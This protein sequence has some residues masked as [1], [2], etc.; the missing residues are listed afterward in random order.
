MYRPGVDVERRARVAPVD[1]AG[2]V[3]PVERRIDRQEVRQVVAVGVHQLVDP[4]DLDRAPELR[5]D[6]ERGCVVE[7]QAAGDAGLD[8]PVAPDRRGG[9][10][11]R[12]DLLREL[13]HRDLVDVAHLAALHLL[14]AGAGHDR[15]DEQRRHE[16]G[17]PPGSQGPARDRDGPHDPLAVDER[18]QEQTRARGCGSVQ[19]LAPGQR[20]RD[21]LRMSPGRGA[22][23]VGAS[24]GSRPACRLDSSNGLASR[25]ARPVTANSP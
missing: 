19:E 1:A 21:P 13:A 5:L 16:L 24:S 6:R 14:R 10:A 20:H 2:R 18:R 22:M 11:G 12:Q 7:E 17:D 9:Q 23:F 15:R 4:L 3:R 8:G 25:T